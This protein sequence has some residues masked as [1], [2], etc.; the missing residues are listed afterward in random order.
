MNTTYLALTIGPIYK[1]LALA[2]RTRELW[3]ASYIFSSLME[4]IV[5]KLN[6]VRHYETI[7]PVKMN[8]STGTKTGAGLYPDRLIVKIKSEVQ[9]SQ[10]DL[11]DKFQ[12]SINTIRD[13]VFEEYFNISARKDAVIHDFMKNYFQLYCIIVQLSER[14]D[15]IKSIFPLL[16][17]LDQ[18]PSFNP[19]FPSNHQLQ[20]ETNYK[21]PLRDLL[22]N[23]KG[24]KLYEGAFQK[25]KTHRFPMILEIATIGLRKAKF[26][27]NIQ[28][29]SSVDTFDNIFEL[30]QK[31]NNE[32]KAQS[33]IELLKADFDDDSKNE[34]KPSKPGQ[35]FRRYHKYMAVVQADGDDMGLLL[36]ALFEYGGTEA[37]QA[38]SEFLIAFGYSASQKIV[39]YDGVPIYLGGDDMLFFAPVRNGD[40]NIFMLIDQLDRLFKDSLSGNTLVLEAIAGWN[41]GMEWDKKRKKVGLPTISYG[42]ALSY[43]KYPLNEAIETARSLLFD[44]AKHFP[45]KNTVSFRLLKHSGHHMGTSINKH[46][47]TWEAFDELLNNEELNK[48]FLNS[49]QYKLEPL[50]PLL[51]RILAGREIDYSTASFKELSIKFLPDEG[52]REFLLENLSDN[53]YNEGGKHTDSRLFIETVFALLLQTYRDMEDCYG[54]NS[55][56]ADQ[57]IDTV[58]ACLRM[59]HFY[60]QPDNKE[61]EE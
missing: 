30:F 61:D 35:Q 21:N 24:S 16:D 59:M 60:N 13:D 33:I 20:K 1:T 51:K 27:Y 15:P 10:A 58:F 3:A 47:R 36:R 29:N 43:H 26:H 54:N 28:F 45:G 2:K 56:S 32:D 46:W 17:S 23:I 5:A 9:T 8:K 42:V 44:T 25:G 49:I 40:Q 7:L 50:R 52:T 18:Q 41:R 38:F 14:E 34:D 53:F 4:Q 31:P 57:A 6:A 22:T 48:T 12:R 55:D 39:G 37:I 11:L 19:L